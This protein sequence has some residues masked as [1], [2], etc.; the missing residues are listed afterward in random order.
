M[1]FDLKAGRVA[2]VLANQHGA[3]AGAVP[4]SH[5]FFDAYPGLE[6]FL[7]EW[8]REWMVA[9]EDGAPFERLMPGNPHSGALRLEAVPFVPSRRADIQ[10]PAVQPG[11]MLVRVS[12]PEG[13]AE[14]LSFVR[15]RYALT[16]AETR[17]AVEVAEGCKPSEIAQRLGLS[18]HT[19]RSHLKR[20]FLK[21]GVHSQA[22]LVRAL[23][24]GDRGEAQPID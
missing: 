21:T 6:T 2:W 17:V 23:L 14:L 22:G 7:C 15:K 4:G 13:Q 16:S 5:K 24:Q 8:S 10:L 1:F 12:L 9:P 18:I 3:I 11:L 19:V 20:I